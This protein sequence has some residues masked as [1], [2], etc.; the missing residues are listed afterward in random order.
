MWNPT[1]RAHHSRAS[2]RYGSDLTD[3]EWQIVEPFLPRAC[4]C[5]RRRRWGWRAILEAIFFE[6]FGG[7][8]RART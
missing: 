8:T 5:G 1:A 7:R 4:R 6:K 2:L 3:A